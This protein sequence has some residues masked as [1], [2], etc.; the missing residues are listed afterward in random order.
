[1]PRQ[2]KRARSRKRRVPI[3]P[4][5]VTAAAG[6]S[7]DA[8]HRAQGTHFGVRGAEVDAGVQ[9]S[10]QLLQ[11]PFRREP[12][13][14]RRSHPR[15]AAR[16]R[17]RAPPSRRAKPCV[18][19]AMD[20]AAVLMAAS[21]R[22]AYGRK[23]QGSREAKVNGNPITVPWPGLRSGEAWPLPA[24]ESFRVQ[25]APPPKQG[26]TRHRYGLNA[27][28]NRVHTALKFRAVQGGR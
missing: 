17:A 22:G 4:A 7:R 21:R 20:A 1:M 2:A 12:R 5:R 10:G 3:R 24:T 27:R 28:H 26:I 8:G 11:P 19:A 9:H 23:P 13:T 14:S 16:S 18:R 15:W 6:S 25:V